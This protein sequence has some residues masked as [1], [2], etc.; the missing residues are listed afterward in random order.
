MKQALIKKTGE[1]FDVVSEYSMMKLTFNLP[2]DFPD[3][4]NYEK[5]ITETW[6]HN[7]GTQVKM[8]TEKDREEYYILSNG[9]TYEV[10][11]LV[12]G[13]DE[14]RDWKLENKLN[15]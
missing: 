13:L 1:I 4:E 3:K 12:I 2:F 10:D 15:L 5:E 8:K 6:I 9:E 11:H 7:G 14:I